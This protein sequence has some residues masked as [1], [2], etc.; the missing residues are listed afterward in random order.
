MNTPHPYRGAAAAD[1]DPMRA[2]QAKVIEQIATSLQTLTAE[3]VD[4]NNDAFDA[5]EFKVALE[6]LRQLYV[7]IIPPGSLT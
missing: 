7:S 1:P 3:L 2:A 5:G 6:A 4:E